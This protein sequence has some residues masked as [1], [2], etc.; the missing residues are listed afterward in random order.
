MERNEILKILADWNFWKKELNCGI[1]RKDYV[2]KA[3]KFLQANMIVSLIGV[4]R[5][6]KSM[7][8]KQI[9]RKLI[10]SGIVNRNDT[11]IINFE[12]K[13]IVE[14][15]LKLLDDFFATYIEEIKP[16]N[17]PIVFL[18]EI[19]KVPQWEK[20]VRT[21]HELEKAKILV[22]G[23][24]SQLT[25]GELSTLLT[26]RHIDIVV[27]PLS[28]AEFLYFRNI[29]VS[30]KLDL[31]TRENEIKSLLREYLKWGGFPEVVLAKDEETKKTILLSYFDD[32]IEKDV[33]ERY[34]IRKR[35]KIKLLAKFYL[36]NISSPI[37]F[38]SLEEL[39]HMNSV[40]IENFSSML[41]ESF[42]IFFTKVF[43]PSV[44]KQEKV[45]RKVYSIDVGISNAIGF[46]IEESIGKLME[47]IVAIELKRRNS[48]SEIYYWK[49]YGK[50]EGKEVDFVVR[51]N[52]NTEELIQVTYA[53]KK[54]EVEKREVEALIKASEQL[55]CNKL[56]I[57]TW[58]YED[59]VEINGKKVKFVPLWKWLLNL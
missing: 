2:E 10:E 24:T 57:I 43:H 54:E 44:K 26:G 21:M 28:F 29:Q 56:I 58:D 22:S 40:T 45:A 53:S 59:L 31:I 8:M 47:N 1:E 55:K 18:D 33:V 36:S 41:E 42:L 23:S 7:L 5:S 32:I 27:F 14:G 35:E 52:F 13:R 25:K 11:L 38:S 9:A 3:M 34:K 46:R 17:K 39:L 6:G 49:E 37:T 12:D 19:H 16:T 4:R 50:A 15:N 20:W 48:T 51:E 30:D